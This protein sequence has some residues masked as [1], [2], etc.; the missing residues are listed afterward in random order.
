MAKDSRYSHSA[1]CAAALCYWSELNDSGL[2]S[3][4]TKS[5]QRPFPYTRTLSADSISTIAFKLW[6]EV[7]ANK[8]PQAKIHTISLSFSGLGTTEVGQRS[9]E[10]FFDGAGATRK[11]PRDPETEDMESGY[12]FICPQ[13]SKRIVLDQA[14]RGDS[15]EMQANA[16]ATLKMQHD[17]YHFAR[18]LA[19]DGFGSD[20]ESKSRSSAKK[21]KK[22]S[23]EGQ[24]ASK[25][26]GIASY[27]GASASASSSK[28]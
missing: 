13:C 11:R 23:K 14:A 2:D 20:E 17:D 4:P 8:P 25:G 19:R 24:I 1:R 6:K 5:K 27:F 16:M 12:S 28:H 3:D 22:P 21:K 26:K 10:G 7:T 18:N 9:I 15:E